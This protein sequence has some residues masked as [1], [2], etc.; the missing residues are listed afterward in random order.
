MPRDSSIDYGVG[1]AFLVALRG[2]LFKLWMFEV[3]VWVDL[4]RQRL[5]LK[6]Q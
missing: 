1:A 2:L 5:L 4:Q 3:V 6:L